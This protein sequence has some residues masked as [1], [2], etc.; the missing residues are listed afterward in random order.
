[1]RAT[2]MTGTG[3]EGFIA[4]DV[5][6]ASE[7]KGGESRL[8]REEDEIGDGDDGMSCLALLWCAHRS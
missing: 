5:I 2:G 1:M 7:R 4:L 8:V 3:G 6:Q